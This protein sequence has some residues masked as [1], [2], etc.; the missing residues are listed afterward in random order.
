M[1]HESDSYILSECEKGESLEPGQVAK[2][3]EYRT[4]V[5]TGFAVAAERLRDI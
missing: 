1:A 3:Q 2:F 4:K 5:K